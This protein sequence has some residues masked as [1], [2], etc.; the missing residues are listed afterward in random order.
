MADADVVLEVPAEWFDN[1]LDCERHQ[2]LYASILVALAD[3]N[4]TVRPIHLPYAA[5]GAERLQ[6]RGQLVVSFHSHGPE[7]N[8]LRLKEAYWPPFYTVDTKGY[9]GFSSLAEGAEDLAAAVRAIPRDTARQFVAEL[10][11]AAIKSNTSKYAQPG[12][13]AGALPNG[14]YFLP[15]QTVEDPVAQLAW[16]HQIEVAARVARIAAD[17][18]RSVVVK[19]HP[20]CRSDA[21]AADLADLARAMPNVVLSEASI[22]PL[23][24]NAD[25]VVGCNSGVLFEALIHG[26]PVVS[27]GASDFVV[28]TRPVH[29]LDELEQALSQA[30]GQDMDFAA[31]FV[32]WFLKVHCVHAADVKAIRGRIAEALDRLDIDPHRYNEEQLDLFAHYARAERSRRNDILNPPA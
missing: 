25:V 4:V 2:R 5:D 14:Y 16:L 12:G 28:A 11:E 30:R 18:G 10:R 23:I 13:N 1:P 17:Q 9:S 20:L 31:R 27:Y 32:T 8:V 22:H 7:G 21:V 26:R 24:R 3:L 6:A 15:L 19:R 29:R